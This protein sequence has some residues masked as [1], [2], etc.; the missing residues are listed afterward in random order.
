MFGLRWLGDG[1]TIKRMP[2]LTIL[3]LCGNTPPTVV[4]IIDCT[5][6]M[7]DGGK[8][9]ATY[10]MEQFWRKV[11]E[12]DVDKELTDCFFF[13]GASNVQT[14]GAILWAR[15][16]RTMCFH[17]GEHILSL[18][19]SDLSK[20]KPIQVSSFFCIVCFVSYWQIFSCLF[21]SAAGCK[22]CLGLVQ[23]MVY[24]PSSLP[25]PALSTMEKNWTVAWCGNKICYLVLCNA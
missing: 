22:M 5:T 16:P 12:I 24:T 4:S 9:D 7:S 10:I 25:N 20:I 6:H 2:L 1:A 23:A 21:S 13:D 8:K 19:F 17:G 18:F 14:A 3:V 15:Y 11:D